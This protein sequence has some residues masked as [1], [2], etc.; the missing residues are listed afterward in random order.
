M[1]RSI[2]IA[3]LVVLIVVICVVIG[4]GVINNRDKTYID[5]AYKSIEKYYQENDAQNIGELKVFLRKSINDNQH[6]ILAK[7]HRGEGQ[8][9]S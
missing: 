7:K 1:K 8:C 4:K 9:H 2:L 6:L 5:K 3:T